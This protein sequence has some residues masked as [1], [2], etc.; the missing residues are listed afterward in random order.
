MQLENS[1]PSLPM[2]RLRTSGLMA[3][4][5]RRSYLLMILIHR[6]KC[7]HTI[8]RYGQT[9]THAQERP[10]EEWSL[11]ATRRS[12]SPPTT[13]HETYGQTMLRSKKR[14]LDGLNFTIMISHLSEE[15]LGGSRLFSVLYLNF[16][17]LG[18]SRSGFYNI[19][20][21]TQGTPCR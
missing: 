19:K 1:P 20:D 18:Y 6:V 15:N 5:A 14:L 7:C 11:S 2:S 4:P 17:V 3:I 8:S 21:G 12:L 16:G 13:T 10:K 9:S